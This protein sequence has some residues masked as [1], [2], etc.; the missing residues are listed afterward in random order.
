MV[1]ER[2]GGVVGYA[3]GSGFSHHAVAETNEDLEA[4]LGAAPGF[5]G[6]GFLLPTRNGEVLRWCLEHGLRVVM[7]MTLMSTGWYQEPVGA[8]LPSIGF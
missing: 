6:P 2:D 8:W 7:P 1:V 3:S 5:V 4:L